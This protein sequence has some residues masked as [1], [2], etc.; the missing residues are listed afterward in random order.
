MV[1][2]D[3]RTE[4]NGSSGEEYSPRQDSPAAE[5]TGT[6]EDRLAFSCL[7]RINQAL[8]K[9]MLKAIGVESIAIPDMNLHPMFLEVF[10]IYDIPLVLISPDLEDRCRDTKIY[11][12][13]IF[14][15][16]SHSLEMYFNLSGILE[17]VGRV[18]LERPQISSLDPEL[19]STRVIGRH[20]D[21]NFGPMSNGKEAVIL[22]VDDP[23]T[24]EP[25]IF[26]IILEAGEKNALKAL[27]QVQEEERD[28]ELVK[29]MAEMSAVLGISPVQTLSFDEK[30]ILTQ[31]VEKSPSLTFAEILN[32]I[33]ALPL[34][35]GNVI[36]PSGTRVGISSTGITTRVSTTDS[37]QAVFTL[38]GLNKRQILEHLVSRPGNFDHLPNGGTNDSDCLVITARI[39]GEELEIQAGIS[40]LDSSFRRTEPVRTE[41]TKGLETPS[42]LTD[43]VKGLKPEK[44]P[45]PFPQKEIIFKNVK[46]TSEDRNHTTRDR[47][48]TKLPERVIAVRTPIKEI[49]LTK[50]EEKMIAKREGTTQAAK[51]LYEKEKYWREKKQK[52]AA[53][54]QRRKQR[55]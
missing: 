53:L 11:V 9:R 30:A 54:R 45:S 15:P 48:E 17:T 19:L 35:D 25:A 16:E 21:V 3:R 50:A 41:E 47:T 4:I 2:P 12:D 8:E 46:R 6:C 26:S 31:P 20:Y 27:I 36:V 32:K 38:T 18:N 34:Y 55:R 13:P 42:A 24:A 39:A 43:L 23:S 14:N 22:I 5:K 10:G 49:K 37:H 28:L 51:Q 52:E 40:S 33:R 7:S 1:Q 44:A 29:T